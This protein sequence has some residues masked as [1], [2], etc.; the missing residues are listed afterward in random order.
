MDI[1]SLPKIL[2]IEDTSDSRALVRRLLDG[3]YIVLGLTFP[4][5]QSN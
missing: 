3:Q 5:G 4:A 1:K 2:Y